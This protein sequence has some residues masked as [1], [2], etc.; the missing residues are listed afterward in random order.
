[1][2]LAKPFGLVA[3]P[4]TKP[5]A[6]HSNRTEEPWCGKRIQNAHRC[7]LASSELLGPVQLL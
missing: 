4:H 3:G 1:M 5:P 2:L 6:K 7:S